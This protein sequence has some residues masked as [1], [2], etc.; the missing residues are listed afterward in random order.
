MQNSSGQNVE[1][2]IPRKWCVSCG[3]DKLLQL[4]SLRHHEPPSSPCSP[5]SL[6]LVDKPV[7]HIQGPRGCAGAPWVGRDRVGCNNEGVAAS[8]H[9]LSQFPPPSLSSR[10][11][12]ATST[13]RQAD[14]MVLSVPLLSVVSSGRRY[15]WWSEGKLWGSCSG[16]MPVSLQPVCFNGVAWKAGG[17][18]NKGCS[19]RW[20]SVCLD[21]FS[22]LVMVIP[23]MR[24]WEGCISIAL[25]DTFCITFPLPSPLT[26][27]SSFSVLRVMLTW[28]LLPLLRKLTW[29][30]SRGAEGGGIND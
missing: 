27:P 3:V 14:T 16:E 12:L 20:W 9:H 6:Q 7:D 25:A 19:Y 4:V 26:S 11:T 8:H 1:L 22:R 21:T 15:G 29:R 17:A 13:P 23:F 5:N 28:P 10:S 2:Y 24:G 18:L 30:L